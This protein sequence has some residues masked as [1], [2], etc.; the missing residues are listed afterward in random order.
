MAFCE[1]TSITNPTSSSSFVA[2]S[3]VNV[4]WN[5]TAG[6]SCSSWNVTQIKLQ[7]NAGGGWSDVSTLFNGL[8]LVSSNS[9]SVTLPSS[10]NSYGDIFRLKVS[11]EEESG[12]F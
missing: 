5:R 4:T 11:Y 12:E 1:I 2:G 3:T 10:L 8:D 9:Q 7:S 6:L